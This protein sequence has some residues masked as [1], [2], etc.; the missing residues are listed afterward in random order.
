MR[1]IESHISRSCIK[2]HPSLLPCRVSCCARCSGGASLARRLSEK[3]F[4]ERTNTGASAT[5]RRN[6]SWHTIG[7]VKRWHASSLIRPTTLLLSLPLKSH[8]TSVRVRTAA[9]LVIHTGRCRL[10]PQILLIIP[11]LTLASRLSPV[12]VAFCSR[13]RLGFVSECSL[14]SLRMRNMGFF[15]A[16]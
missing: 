11:G 4:E 16:G 13:F 12:V 10:R 8:E 3:L 14:L 7:M 5:R 2:I 15:K 6:L 1:K 9:F